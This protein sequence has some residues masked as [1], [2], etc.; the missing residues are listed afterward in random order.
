MHQIRFHLGLC[1][2]LRTG[3]V[4]SAPTDHQLDLKG[5]TSKGREGEGGQDRGQ[6]E[7]EVFFLHI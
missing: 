1:P 2:R 5:P 7:R 6:E 3:V 4:H